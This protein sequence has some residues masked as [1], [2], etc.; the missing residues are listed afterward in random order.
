MTSIRTTLIN[1]LKHFAAFATCLN[2]SS[3]FNFFYGPAGHSEPYRG[4][5]Q[6]LGHLF[7]YLAHKDLSAEMLVLAIALLLIELN[8]QY[9]FNRY[10]RWMYI[11]TSLIGSWA[12]VQIL[13]FRIHQRYQIEVP[14]TA[15]LLPIISAAAYAIAYA[16]VRDHY[17]QRSMIKALDL[18]RTRNELNALKAQLNPHFLFNGLNYLYGTALKE[19]APTTA[20]GI[21]KLSELLRYTVHGID[22]DLVPLK[23]EIAFIHNYLD[24][25]K[26]RLPTN[27]RITVDTQISTDNGDL[28]IA[29]LLL[30]TYI[31]NAFKYGISNDEECLIRLLISQQYGTLTMELTNTI[32]RTST[33][34]STSNTVLSTAQKR[35]ELLYPERHQLQI[36][37]D[38]HLFKVKL[39]LDLTNSL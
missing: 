39:K 27:G 37:H 12:V 21:V 24:L 9:I 34:F 6:K 32:V 26:A 19:D 1:W 35:L 17:D 15:R 7:R 11:L 28:I 38:Q 14:V 13:Y 5:G 3:V 8:Y 18:Q 31:E 4:Y 25:Q 29:P 10:P 2:L 20:E 33:L 36:E 16:F 23:D 30:L 22:H